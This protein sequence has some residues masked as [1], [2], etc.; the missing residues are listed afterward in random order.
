MKQVRKWTQKYLG[1]ALSIVCLVA[2]IAFVRPDELWEAMQG[3]DLLDL[4]FGVV[5]MLVYMLGRAVRWQWLL[6]KQ[7]SWQRVFH[8]QNI[9]YL[10]TYLL[11]FRLGDVARATL[12]GQSGTPSTL[13]AGSTV[14]V[15][16]LL[17]LGVMVLLLGITVGQTGEM[18]ASYQLILQTAGILAFAGI[19][20]LFLMAR[21]QTVL[22]RFL[23]KIPTHDYW[24]PYLQPI[25]AGLQPFTQWRATFMLVLGT[26]AIWLPMLMAHFW[27]LRA[28]G[29]PASLSWRASS[30]GRRH[31]SSPPP[32]RRGR[33]VFSMPVSPPPSRLSRG[34]PPCPRRPLL[35]FTIR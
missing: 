27:V 23:A 1:I 3:V 4:G 30:P 8:V 21:F 34:N 31:W 33:L 15:E 7:I 19:L 9:G 26:V 6:D 16:R 32:P 10:V 20:T 24:L 13:Q 12:I 18:P 2:F 22:L 5:G 25:L 14:V 17:D 28:V 29:L 11:P 35:C